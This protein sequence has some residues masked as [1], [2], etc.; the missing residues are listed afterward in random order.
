MS[1]SK[2]RHSKKRCPKYFS[3]L[4]SRNGNP[5][6]VHPCTGT[7]HKFTLSPNNLIFKLIMFVEKTRHLYSMVEIKTLRIGKNSVQVLTQK[8]PSPSPFCLLYGSNSRK[9]IS[10]HFYGF[11]S[12]LSPLHA[13]VKIPST[14]F[15]FP[16]SFPLCMRVKFSFSHAG[17]VSFD[18]ILTP[19]SISSPHMGQ[20]PPDSIPTHLFDFSLTRECPIGMATPSV[21]L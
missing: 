8:L 10:Y 21:K 5:I 9:C 13:P 7:C 12:L 19:H 18:S 1:L 2:K 4:C 3:Y 20:V 17:Q 11:S 16:L 15:S 6:N 14:R